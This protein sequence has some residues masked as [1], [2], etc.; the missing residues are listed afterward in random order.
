MLYPKNF[1]QQLDKQRNRITYARII[2][3]SFDER[4]QEMIEGRVTSGSIN[5]D[6]ASAIRRSC[7]LSMISPEVDVSDFYW[8]INT[9]FKLSIGIENHIDNNYPDII[10]FE[11]GIY[12]ITSFNSSYST[13]SY[14]INISGKDKMCLL[15]GE[16]GG[17]LGSSVDFGTIE[18]EY[19]PGVWKK[20][21]M[22]IKD[23]IREMVHAYAG[24]P[25]HNIII[26]DLEKYGMTL[27][28]YRYNDPMF[29]L[30]KVGS[31]EY[32]QAFIDG[33]I[34]VKWNN[35]EKTLTDLNTEDSNF[36]FESLSED[37]NSPSL[38]SSIVYYPSDKNTEEYKY[39]IARID[40]GE[41]AGYTEGALV[42]PSDLIANIGESITS[43]LDK[44]KNFLGEFEY[45]YN[46]EGQFI[47]QEKKNYISTDWSPLAKDGDGKTYVKDLN[48]NDELVYSFNNSEL[49][50]SFNNTPNIA[51]LKNDFS[52]WGTR[53]GVSGDNLPIHM[54]YALDVKPI[55]YKTIEV[56]DEDL[57]DYNRVNNMNLKGQ[58]SITYLA[59]DV[60]NKNSDIEYKCDWR[61]LIYRMALD[62]NKYNHLDD[63]ENRVAAANPTLYP[64][65]KT[66]YEQ[67]Y[68]DLQGFWRELYNPFLSQEILWLE[69]QIKNNPNKQ[70][71]LEEQLKNKKEQCKKYYL[72][73]NNSLQ[74]WAKAVYET[75]ESLIFWFD[76]MEAQGELEQFSVPALGARTKV[77]NDNSV[78]AIYYRETPNIIFQ[79]GVSGSGEQS[80]YRYIN[81]PSAL[82]MFSKSTQ[83]RSA[84][85]TI[86]N[87]LYNHSYCIESISATTIPIYYLDANSRI[88]I[89]DTESGIEGDYIISKLSL[90][91]SYN[92]TMNITATKAAPKLL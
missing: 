76:F 81:V 51:N 8:T 61:E 69:E 71:V 87:L 39:T 42:Y 67:Y 20:I 70:E 23:I 11:Q 41:T 89:N 65:G 84:K 34:K 3:L 44:I 15:N 40:Y 16:V 88:Y 48:A 35:E 19:S 49:F 59:S 63:F 12:L 54:R 75:P 77:T 47:F 4:P 6:G 33:K 10:W 30:R 62:Y 29:L 21:K 68:I 22:P 25:F 45:F 74:G 31:N 56:A 2:S 43:V 52:V 7:Q 73:I 53:K 26:N 82:S 66:E 72:D 1:L 85:E 78:K 46:L 27:Q 5:I 92:G 91:L 50:T 57:K 17:S 80:G 86:D 58:T 83:G 18:Q 28:E 14:T 38:N 60:Y 79:S 64:T 37:F 32:S 55:S 13:N 24:E 90:Q 9:K 36:I